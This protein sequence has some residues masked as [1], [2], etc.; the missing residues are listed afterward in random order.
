VMSAHIKLPVQVIDLFY[1]HTQI[2]S[3]EQQFSDDALYKWIVITEHPPNLK[4]QSTLIY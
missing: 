2:V 1:G 4:L 3:T